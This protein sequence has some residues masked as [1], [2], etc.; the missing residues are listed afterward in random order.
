MQTRRGHFHGICNVRTHEIWKM[1]HENAGYKY[2]GADCNRLFGEYYK[3][4]LFEF[5]FG[6]RV[7]QLGNFH[8]TVSTRTRCV[9][10]ICKV[11][12]H[13]IWSM[14]P[15]SLWWLW[16]PIRHWVFWRYYKVSLLYSDFTREYCN[17]E[18]F[19]A[20]CKQGAVVM[21]TSANYG[22]MRFGRCIRK[23]YDDSGNPV[24]IGCDEDIIR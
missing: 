15:E 21:M 23:T 6:K 9:G 4:R 22:R 7:L 19:T 8:C 14:P 16:K 18:T 11:W 20:Q 24:D 1:H 10:H 13:E 17:W 5:R 2:K 12:T 3:V